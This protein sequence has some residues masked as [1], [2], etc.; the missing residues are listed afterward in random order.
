MDAS[1]HSEAA[2][3]LMHHGIRAIARAEQQGIRV[4]LEYLEQRKAN[5]TS[6]INRLERKFKASDFYQ[7]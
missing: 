4:D 5:L 1:P 3:R 2:Y 6:K 7:H